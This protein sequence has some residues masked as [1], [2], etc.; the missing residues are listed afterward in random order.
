MNEL[1]SDGEIIVRS[2]NFF[3]GEL[4]VCSGIVLLEFDLLMVKQSSL[5]VLVK[6]FFYLFLL[7]LVFYVGN[8]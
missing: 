3:I 8:I 7:R 1:G 5:V 6:E 2:G 4:A